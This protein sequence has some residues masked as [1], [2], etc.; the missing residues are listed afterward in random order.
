MSDSEEDCHTPSEASSVDCKINDILNRTIT[1]DGYIEYEI[2]IVNSQSPPEWF[3]RSDLWDDGVNTR[4]M[5]AYD[6]K[7]P[8]AWDTTCQHCGDPFQRSHDG[9]EECRCDECGL[10]T[11]HLNGV[12]Y[13]CKNHPVI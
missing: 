3:D 4:K 10:P 9:C 1:E 7:F 8:I 6:K 12:N 13:G 2:T 5:E 11:R